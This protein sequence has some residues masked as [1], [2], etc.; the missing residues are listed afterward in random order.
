MR[1]V[2]C[3]ALRAARALLVGVTCGTAEPA[4]ILR[5]CDAP[6]IWATKR[7]S[8]GCFTRNRDIGAAAT[9]RNL[10]GICV[11]TNREPRTFPIQAAVGRP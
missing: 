7:E 9:W 1:G 8:F 10:L 6:G 3:R 11:A 5:N 2:Q 4:I